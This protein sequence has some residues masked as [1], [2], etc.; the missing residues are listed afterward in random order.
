MQNIDD[1]ATFI[2]TYKQLQADN[3]SLRNKL[4]ERERERDQAESQ[5]EDPTHAK[6]AAKLKAM[7]ED[8]NVMRQDKVC[9]MI[10]VGELE[11]EALTAKDKVATLVTE[12]SKLKRAV[13]QLY[14]SDLSLHEAMEESIRI[15]KEVQSAL[16]TSSS[17]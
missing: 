13:A 8:M 11:S 4:A 15:W 14:R 9:W 10:H 7:R 12:N 3:T 17:E 6:H 1:F 16:M 5:L 2:K